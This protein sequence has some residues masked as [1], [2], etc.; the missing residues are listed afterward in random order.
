MLD[1]LFEILNEFGKE[2]VEL[3]KQRHEEAGQKENIG[4][5]PDYLDCFIMRMFYEVKNQT[6]IANIGF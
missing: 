2:S 4:R 3:L 6:G 1:Q 5:S